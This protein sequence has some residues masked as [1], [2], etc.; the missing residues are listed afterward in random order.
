M[1]GPA[2]G[3]GASAGLEGHLRLRDLAVPLGLVVA[4]GLALRLIIAYVL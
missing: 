2:P 1:P 3:E 4:L